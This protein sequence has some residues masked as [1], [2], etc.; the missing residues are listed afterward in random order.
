MRK[1]ECVTG[2]AKKVAGSG[3]RF[4]RFSVIVLSKAHPRLRRGTYVYT[5]LRYFSR[6]QLCKV[7]DIVLYIVHYII[8]NVVVSIEAL[9]M[10]LLQCRFIGSTVSIESRVVMKRISCIPIDLNIIL[11]RI[12]CEIKVSM[13]TRPMVLLAWI[14]P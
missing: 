12:R 4:C 1:V 5:I 3:Y 9:N 10:I 14:E 2:L 7:R 8:I 11:Y 6:E 13:E